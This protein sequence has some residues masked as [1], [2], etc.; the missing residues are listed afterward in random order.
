VWKRLV[1]ELDLLIY[2]NILQY[3]G[4]SPFD[5]LS[6]SLQYMTQRVEGA[7]GAICIDKYGK[8]G[9]AFN[10]KRMAWAVINKDES[11]CGINPGEKIIFS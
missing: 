5:A 1:E 7:G 11:L 9:F 4:E 6:S 3:S 10:T 2:K 8:Y